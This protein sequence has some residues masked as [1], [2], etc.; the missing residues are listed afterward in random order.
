MQVVR[1][2][3][4]VGEYQRPKMNDGQAVRVHRPF[5]LF[6]D[7]VVNNAEKTCCEQ[8][9]HRVMAV[10]PLHHRVLHAS[11]GGIRLHPACG[12]HGRIDDVQHG[13][14]NDEGTV[15]PV[16]HVNM[17]HLANANRAKKYDGVGHPN[18]R[19]Q[20]RNRPFQLGIFFAACVAH[21]Q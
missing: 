19:N 11:V 9:A 2:R 18:D 7:E 6:G 3:P 13:H 14:G 20:Q 12:H 8:K 1:A 15:K 17:P 10:P 16:S 5:R 4:H 21:R